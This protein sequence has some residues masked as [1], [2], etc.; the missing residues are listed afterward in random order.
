M[1]NTLAQAIDM[2]RERAVATRCGVLW[3]WHT[4][5]SVSYLTTPAL[6][7]DP[8]HLPR[9]PYK[10]LPPQRPPRIH[11]LSPLPPHP[12]PHQTPMIGDEMLPWSPEAMEEVDLDSAMDFVENFECAWQ[13][14]GS[15]PEV[16]GGAKEKA[17]SRA[18]GKR[19][20]GPS[21]LPRP[22]A[23][24]PAAAATPATPRHALDTTQRP[25]LDYPARWSWWRAE[26]SNGDGYGYHT[27]HLPYRLDSRRPKPDRRRP[28]PSEYQ[29]PRNLSDILSTIQHP[30]HPDPAYYM[31]H[32]GSFVYWLIPVH[33]PVVVPG[34]EDIVV[35]P[36]AS[37][38]A[39]R[40]IFTATNMPIDTGTD[41]R[42]APLRWTP[43]LLRAFVHD[44]FEPT[45]NDP[46]HRY[47]QL[48]LRTCGPW[49]SPFLTGLPPPP[50]LRE[51]QCLPPGTSGSS[52]PAIVEC[53]D[54][55]RIY[56]EASKALKVRWWLHWWQVRLDGA[57]E[58][59]AAPRRTGSED[60]DAGGNDAR[61][62]VEYQPFKRVRLALVSHRSEVLMVA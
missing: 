3:V 24:A 43:A 19:R 39:S 45:Y 6:A 13:E 18:K 38:W 20:A 14:A 12:D 22:V 54:H 8:G 2:E 35:D 48:S 46:H 28:A 40:G 42:P 58:V 52:V 55:V 15:W 61:P 1:A 21:P 33:G 5:A 30:F 10:Y 11:E 51:H 62:K 7:D 23:A 29:L 53:G 49:P 9:H 41:T 32:S 16:E 36:T 25:A 17:N 27:S 26:I 50:A 4:L 59:V 44:H 56:C 37:S 47:G 60:E 31:K 57:G 34:L